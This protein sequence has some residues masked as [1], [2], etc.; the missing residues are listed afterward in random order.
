MIALLGNGTYFIDACDN[1]N[2]FLIAYAKYNGGI[3][4][5]VFQILANSNE[6]STK[7]LVKYINDHT[8]SYDEEITEIYKVT[9]KIY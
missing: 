4:M 9:E 5:K 8:Y 6:M 7:E 3:D 1:I 2:E